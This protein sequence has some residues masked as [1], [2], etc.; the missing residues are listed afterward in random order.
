MILAALA[1]ACHPLDGDRI[2]GRDLAEASAAFA[3]IAPDAVFGVTPIPGVR[4]VMRPE[5]LVRL[6][7]ANHLTIPNPLP[8]ICFERATEPLTAERL[9]PVLQEA[10]NLTEAKIEIEEFSHVAVPKCELEFTRSGLSASGFW[11][12]HAAYSENRSMPVWAKVRVTTEQSWIEAAAPIDSSKIISADQLVLRSG[13]RFPFGPA[14]LAS[15]DAAAGRKS[16]RAIKPG[17]PIFSS[18]LISPHDVERGEKVLVEV[19]VGQADITFEGIAE[20]SGRVGESVLIRNP[21][22]D[23]YFQARIESKGKVSIRK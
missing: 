19:S 8:Q 21:Q 13:P 20:S 4:R 7:R 9:L 3:S 2:T 1:L 18:M 5:E 23:H 22:S 11:R 17:E 14:P 10:L 6:A 12:G 16:L 15:I